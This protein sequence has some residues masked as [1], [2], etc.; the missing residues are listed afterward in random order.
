VSAMP[1]G[2]RQALLACE[3]PA[4]ILA[5]ADQRTAL[6][7]KAPADDV[8]RFRGAPIRTWYVLA[9]TEA[10][11]VLCLALEILDDARHPFGIETFLDVAKAEELALAE[12]LAEQDRLALHFY[13]RAL[14]YRFTKTIPQ[15]ERQ[16]SELQALIR[17]ALEHLHC[18][19][20]PDWLAARARFMRQ[21]AL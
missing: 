9:R 20:A 16:R 19:E 2:L 3:G 21:T 17:L 7:V 15:R 14:A 18:V 4:G 12:R 10:G 1:D 5:Q 6:V 11:P 13:D 8:A